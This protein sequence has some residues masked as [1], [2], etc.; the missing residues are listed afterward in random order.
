MRVFGK[1]I[2]VLAGICLLGCANSEL[3]AAKHPNILFIAVDD[4]NDW[5]GC[6]GG[7]PQAVTPNFD[8]L[9]KRGILF[10]NAHCVAPACR[11]SRSAI[12]SGLPPQQTGAWSNRSDDIIKDLPKGSLLPHY[13]ANHGY[14]TFG[15]GKLLHGDE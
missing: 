6:M 13:L 8:R 15:A 14:R 4:L 5:I 9:A 7:H 11:P 3:I 12:F 1:V 10:N 2:R